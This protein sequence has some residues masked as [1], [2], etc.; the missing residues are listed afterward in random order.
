MMNDLKKNEL[1]ETEMETIAGGVHHTM[2]GQEEVRKQAE[3][4][5]RPGAHAHSGASGKW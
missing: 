1:N 2:R 4:A 5:K 3:A